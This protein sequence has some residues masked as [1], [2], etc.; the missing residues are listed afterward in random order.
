MPVSGFRQSWSQRQDAPLSAALPLIWALACL[1]WLAPRSVESIRVLRFTAGTAALAAGVLILL[2]PA[3]RW[4]IWVAWLVAGAAFG[5]AEWWLSGSLGA[6]VLFLVAAGHFWWD[7]RYIRDEREEP[8]SSRPT[9]VAEAVARGDDHEL[10]GA[11]YD[12][13]VKKHGG[14]LNAA[15]LTRVEQAFLLPYH[16]LG[17]IENGGFNYLFEGDFAGDTYFHLTAAA[18][19]TIGADDAAAAF[20]KALA[21]FPDSKPPIDIDERLRIY[22]QGTGRLRH[23]IDA[24]FWDAGKEVTSKLATYIRAHQ[25]IFAKGKSARARRSAKRPVKPAPSR[26]GLDIEQLPHWARVAFAVRCAR[27]VQP[28]FLESW[29]NVRPERCDAVAQAIML[30]EQSAA[31]GYRMPDLKDA[32]MQATI[33]AGAALMALYGSPKEDD[34][35]LP[36]DGNAGTVASQVAKV[37][38]NAARAAAA[39]PAESVEPTRAAVSFARDL[40]GA[41]SELQRTFDD[42][43]GH[44][45]DLAIV[46][47][48]T[49]QT[50]VLTSVWRTN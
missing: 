18:F 45:C 25:D 20:R 3:W 23:E 14:D 47:G 49:D 41:A 24:Q 44:L 40:V 10:C 6:L 15:D 36:P 46:K 37:A 21:L 12:A 26:T 1:F 8:I 4:R 17:I 42:D 9:T 5:V 7:E 48:W 22:R 28:L 38:E 34:E 33:V 30:A 13:V 19:E 27:L 39:A 31:A 29:P 11:A 43:F 2:L 32:I 50:P 16:A 35:P